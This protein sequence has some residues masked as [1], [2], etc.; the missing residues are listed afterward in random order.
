MSTIFRLWS[1]T[2]AAGLPLR[3]A[4]ASWY[5][6]CDCGHLDN[7]PSDTR[8]PRGLLVD[9]DEP[10]PADVPQLAAEAS[11]VC[12]PAPVA[13]APE[14]E[15]AAVTEPRGEDGS[16]VWPDGLPRSTAGGGTVAANVLEFGTGA[17]NIDACRVEGEPWKA[18]SATGLGKVKFFTEGETPEIDKAPH[19]AGRWPAN[20]ALDESQAEA[21]D[22]QSGIQRGA[23][24]FFYVAKAPQSERPAT[25]SQPYGSGTTSRLSKW[26]TC[27]RVWQRPVC[28]LTD[29]RRTPLGIGSQVRLPQPHNLPAARPDVTVL[30]SVQRHPATDASLPAR[31]LPIVPVVAVELDNETGRRDRRVGGELA[32][33]HGLPQVLHTE[34]I[35]ERVAEPFGLRR[36]AKLLP[37]VHL[38]QHG[39]ALRIGVTA[40]KRAVSDPVG[41]GRRARRGPVEGAATRLARV[42]RLAVALSRVVAVE[43]AV[44][45]FS[46]RHTGR[47]HVEGRPAP[48]TG[49]VLTGAALGAR[50]RSVAGQ[51]A[52]ARART[53]PLREGHP[54]ALAG[55]RPNFVARLTLCHT[56]DS[57]AT[58]NPIGVMRYA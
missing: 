46:L 20:V 2:N 21:L 38:K 55:V 4:T 48:L 34:A 53:A 9:S 17:L 16:F 58:I 37:S 22:E 47:G 1:A 43:R 50:R 5:Q 8:G 39:A 32:T 52:V 33:K 7:L 57:T 12:K 6:L 15:P 23:S 29:T 18:H 36:A 42:L 41:A 31:A 35:Q 56:P 51:R 40:G 10:I 54:A 14:P 19:T 24:R 3:N 11:H 45:P 25:A 44:A 30:R 26:I 49:S 28:K 27:G 13:A